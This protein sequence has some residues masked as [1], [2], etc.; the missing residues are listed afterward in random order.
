M[1]PNCSPVFTPPY[2]QRY[3]PITGKGAVRSF[4]QIEL[5]K[6][7]MSSRVL[8]RPS[9]QDSRKRLINSAALASSWRPHKQIVLPLSKLTQAKYSP[10]PYCLMTQK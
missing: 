1:K 6:V 2:H 3:G 7:K 8:I 9:W 4:T 5:I 10:V